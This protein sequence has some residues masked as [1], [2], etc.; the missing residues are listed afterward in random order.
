M[1]Q[2]TFNIA[3]YRPLSVARPRETHD[4]FTS[5][6][7]R[8]NGFVVLASNTGRDESQSSW[9]QVQPSVVDIRTLR[10]AHPPRRLL[11]HDFYQRRGKLLRFANE[12]S[13]RVQVL[14]VNVAIT[15]SGVDPFPP[16]A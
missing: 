4:P 16:A 9:M 11:L 14:P 8:S 10:D 5:R 7:V 1:S 2:F 13:P 15:T 6:S 3:D 12:A